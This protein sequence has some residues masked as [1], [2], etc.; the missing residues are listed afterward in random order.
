MYGLEING[1]TVDFGN[2][3]LDNITTNIRK[4]CITGLIGRNGAGKSTLIK[5]LMRQQDAVAGNFKFD[6]VRVRY[7]ALQYVRKAQKNG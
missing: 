3:K 4:G 1:L 5:T 6:C 2:F 7:P